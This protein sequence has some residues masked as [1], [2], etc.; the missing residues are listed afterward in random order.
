MLSSLHIAENINLLKKEIPEH[1]K[2]VAVTKK[3]APDIVKDAY[4]AGQRAFGE[5]R[6]QE[7]LAKYRHLPSDIEWHLIGH[8]QTN[9]V[10]FV[11]P[12]I[13]LIHS[14]DSLK[15]LS[16]INKEAIKI[17]RITD[18]LLQIHIAQEETKFG[19]SFEEARSILNSNE[20][21]EFKNVRIT[22]LMGMATF[23]ENTKQIEH[24]FELL[25]AY[26]KEIKEK[27]FPHHLY[28][29]ELSM[30]MSGDYKLALAA[31]ATIIRIGSLI[32]GERKLMNK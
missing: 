29:K 32:F 31:G 5:N 20:F 7:L 2:L 23:T 15:L 30:G 27:W 19:L 8:L 4:D 17:N 10:K 13:R 26:F 11:V 18:C 25:T 9:K 14:V 22:G 12:F 6:V 21:W 3:I 24:E 28:F 1:V 16:E